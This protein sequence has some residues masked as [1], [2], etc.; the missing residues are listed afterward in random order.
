M[1]VMTSTPQA[2]VWQLEARYSELFKQTCS[3]LG[4][5]YVPSTGGVDDVNLP[6]ILDKLTKQAETFRDKYLSPQTIENPAPDKDPPTIVVYR[7]LNPEFAELLEQGNGNALVDAVTEFNTLN[8]TLYAIIGLCYATGYISND[9]DIPQQVQAS[10]KS[11]EVEGKTWGVVKIYGNFD[12]LAKRVEPEVIEKLTAT[13]AN[14]QALNA[15]KEWLEFGRSASYPNINAEGANRELQGLVKRSDQIKSGIKIN[16]DGK[17]YSPSQVNFMMD[18]FTLEQRQQVTAQLS[19]GL[20]ANADE[21]AAI[22]KDIIKI[23]KSISQERGFDNLLEDACAKSGITVKQAESIINKAT[24]SFEHT[25]HRISAALA[26]YHGKSPISYDNL[27]VGFVQS[28]Q[29]STISWDEAVNA[30]QVVADNISN[31][32]GG[33]FKQILQEGRIHAKP[34][35]GKTMPRTNNDVGGM[36]FTQTTFDNL[37][38]SAGLTIHEVLHVAHDMISWA[39]H[40]VN[41][42]GTLLNYFNPVTSEVPAFQGEVVWY[43]Q[44]AKDVTIPAAELE[45][46]GKAA[47]RVS[48]V[49]GTEV[50]KFNTYK[51]ITESITELTTEAIQGIWVEELQKSSGPDVDVGGYESYIFESSGVFYKHFDSLNYIYGAGVSLAA[52]YIIDA[53][54]QQQAAEFL[55]ANGLNGAYSGQNPVTEF[56]NRYDEFLQKGQLMTTQAMSQ[57]LGIEAD[58]LSEL[59]L[60][61]AADIAQQVETMVDKIVSA[62]NTLQQASPRVQREGGRDHYIFNHENQSELL[63]AVKNATGLNVSIRKIGNQYTCSVP[64]DAIDK[65]PGNWQ[66]AVEAAKD[67]RG[68]GKGGRE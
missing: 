55:N 22:L 16:I 51:R 39:Y 25:T 65:L 28:G 27:R 64:K 35:P 62:S 38:I 46:L 11:R 9:P 13:S 20:N 45:A 32:V 36:S 56:K 42:I 34:A 40:Q 30:G 68:G 57:V 3:D 60:Q 49:L 33:T 29:A 58:V 63:H 52:A 6:V 47:Q 5:D 19:A 31:L 14:Q 53:D 67:N 41:N 61:Y 59:G 23:R 10:A 15:I 48:S 44:L 17:E 7:Q 8:T 18:G 54:N 37:I 12:P 43:T 21:L 1:L 4:I 50:A 2:P 24:T 66:A 26:K